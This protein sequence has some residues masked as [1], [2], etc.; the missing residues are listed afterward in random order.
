MKI[1]TVVDKTSY[2]IL[3][4]PP[5]NRTEAETHSDLGN[6][7]LVIS[8]EVLIFYV[9]LFFIAQIFLTNR[10]TV[11]NQ[12]ILKKSSNQIK[13]LWSMARHI[14]R[15]AEQMEFSFQ[16][17]QLLYLIYE[18]A[19]GIL[20]VFL[21]NFMCSQL[22]SYKKPNLVNT[23]EN[24]WESKD[25]YNISFVQ[26]SSAP[27]IFKQSTE[28][29]FKQN[30]WRESIRQWQRIEKTGSDSDV[31]NL[32]IFPSSE[33][34]RA[35]EHIEHYSMA[36]LSSILPAKIVLGLECAQENIKYSHIHFSRESFM[37]ET[38]ALIGSSFIGEELRD[39]LEF[40][41]HRVIESGLQDLQLSRGHEM[42]LENIPLPGPISLLCLNVKAWSD[43]NNDQTSTLKLDDCKQFLK[44]ISLFFV[45]V[46]SFALVCEL[47]VNMMQGN[48]KTKCSTLN[49]TKI[50]SRTSYHVT[51]SPRKK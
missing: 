10:I 7:I 15:Q 44:H 39:R 6:F 42:T 5:Y 11:L 20:F 32:Q 50:K 12:R 51:Q 17:Q 21:F 22:V 4:R 26:A 40:Y 14:L 25:L 31:T 29:S 48:K 35:P 41:M 38:M 36:L 33:M 27:G 46:C 8:P 49:V 18:C 9:S 47:A 2:H 37:S 30:F 23:L 3:T 28:G 24:V 16:T 34:L 45:I 43:E 19:I 13:L 1:I